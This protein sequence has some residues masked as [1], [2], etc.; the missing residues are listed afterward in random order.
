MKGCA[1]DTCVGE[2]SLLLAAD[3]LSHAAMTSP[4]VSTILPC[5]AEFTGDGAVIVAAGTTV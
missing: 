1:K 5:C 4:W 3:G 2:G